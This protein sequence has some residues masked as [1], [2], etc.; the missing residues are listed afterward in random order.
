MV[1]KIAP[2][3]QGVKNGFVKSSVQ[4]KVQAFLF[5]QLTNSIV[6]FVQAKRVPANKIKN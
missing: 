5:S 3:K 1:K 4:P 2:K 6:K